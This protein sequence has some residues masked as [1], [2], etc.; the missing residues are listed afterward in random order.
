MPTFTL[1]G[2]TIEVPKGGQSAKA[3]RPAV[4]LGGELVQSA[5]AAEFRVLPGHP[6]PQVQATRWALTL[7]RIEDLPPAAAEAGADTEID[8]VN[9]GE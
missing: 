1:H 9:D 6:S 7:P 2:I 3:S 8:E 4:Y 5:A